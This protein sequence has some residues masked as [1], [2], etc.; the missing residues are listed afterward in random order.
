MDLDRFCYRGDGCQQ[1]NH[2]Q[3]MAGKDIDTTGFN[4]H[5]LNILQAT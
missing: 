1:A 4:D 2:G 3:P 5:S